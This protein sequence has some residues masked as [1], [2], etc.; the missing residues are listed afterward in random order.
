[1]NSKRQLGLHM[2]HARA[3]PHPCC[4]TPIPF[5]QHKAYTACSNNQHNIR[6]AILHIETSSAGK[7]LLLSAA[8]LL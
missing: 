2:M 3:Q 5:G 8:S 4:S 1:L 7:T 6:L